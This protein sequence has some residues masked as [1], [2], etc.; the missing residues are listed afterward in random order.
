MP[1]III[2]DTSCLI[3]LSKI[4]ALDILKKLYK[5]IFVTEDVLKEYGLEIPDWIRIKSPSDKVKQQILETQLGKGESSSIALAVE[6]KE[7]VL[8]LDDQ[9]ARKIAEIL[10]LKITGTL[11]IL[12][13]AKQKGHIIS[14]KSVLNK[15]KSSGFHISKSLELYALKEAGE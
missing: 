12:I 7:C 1:E 5:N 6:L 14:F 10:G 11:A 8:I 4:N 3:L 9:K 15:I 2:S 13:K